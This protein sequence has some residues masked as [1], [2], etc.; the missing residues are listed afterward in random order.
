MVDHKD[1]E[2]EGDLMIATEHINS[3]KINFLLKEARGLICLALSSQQVYQLK[4]PMIKSPDH[5]SHLNHAA[6]T[7]SIEAKNGISTGISAKERAHT[8]LTAIHENASPQDIVCPGHVFPLAAK[9]GG[10]LV[11]PGH[12]EACVDLSIL[13]R[14]NPAG[15]IC[16]VLNDEGDAAHNDYLSVF[17]EKFNIKIGAVEDLVAYRKGL[18]NK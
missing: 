1:R 2:N 8:I 18:Q 15:V 4:L 5:S 7:F 16:E 6:F 17:S 9:D 12:T 14:L 10:V 3:Q 13:A 11:R